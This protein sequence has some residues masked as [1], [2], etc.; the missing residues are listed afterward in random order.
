V[1]LLLRNDNSGPPGAKSFANP[2]ELG[3]LIAGSLGV[4][5]VSSL[6]SILKKAWGFVAIFDSLRQNIPPKGRITVSLVWDFRGRDK[7]TAGA[8]S[9]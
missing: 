9:E 3:K 7:G 5:L 2:L 4:S 6:L 1:H 8:F